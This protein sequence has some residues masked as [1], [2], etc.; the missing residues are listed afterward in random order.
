M[1]IHPYNFS[2]L[3]SVSLAECRLK[4]TLKNFIPEGE[5]RLKLLLSVEK[6]LQQSI[7]GGCTL[8]TKEYRVEDYN[9]WRGRIGGEGIYSMFSTLPTGA[10][11]LLIWDSVLALSLIDRML[12]GE[13]TEI[14]AARELSEIENGVLSFLLMQI[15]RT[16]HTFQQDEGRR[17]THLEPVS[18]S[19]APIRFEKVFS[20]QETL[21]AS[22]LG[23]K[24][25]VVVDVKVAIPELIGQ[26]QLV[27]PDLFIEEVLAPRVS[28]MKTELSCEERQERL[29]LLGDLLFPMRASIGEA[30]LSAGEMVDLQP[31]DIILLDQPHCQLT[32]GKIEG[33]VVFYPECMGAPTIVATIQDLGPPA[34]MAVKEIYREA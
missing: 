11:M 33:D 30:F 34:Q 22:L 27:L 32:G 13:L 29:N 4:E 12:G 8:H 25:V 2:R 17:S 31:G 19:F 14:P 3:E 26:V 18:E 23:V 10:K 28:A 6:V 20:D 15:A 24:H 7:R 21:E 9:T 16:F 5:A 1:V